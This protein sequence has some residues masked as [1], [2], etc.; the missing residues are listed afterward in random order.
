MINQAL[1]I[2]RPNDKIIR[3][4]VFK[5]FL[6]S[7][8]GNE[9]L[10]ENSTGSAQ[11]NIAKR[12]VLQSIPFVLPVKETQKIMEIM[13]NSITDNILLSEKNTSCLN[14]LKNILLSKTTKI[15]KLQSM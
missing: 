15:E 11:V 14:K 10:V 4:I 2:L 12:E 6:T 7:K 9:L 3:P 8:K 5:Y 1:L 13:L